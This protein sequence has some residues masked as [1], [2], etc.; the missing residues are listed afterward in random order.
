MVWAW[1]LEGLDG[2]TRRLRLMT[3][4]DW[5]AIGGS[6]PWSPAQ[7]HMARWQRA[8]STVARLTPTPGIE[9]TC[10]DAGNPAWASGKATLPQNSRPTTVQGTAREAQER[11]TATKT[12]SIEASSAP[13][14]RFGLGRPAS[15]PSATLSRRDRAPWCAGDAR[16]VD[17]GGVVGTTG[18][19]CEA[20]AD[21][22]TNTDRGT[23][24]TSRRETRYHGMGH[25]CRVLRYYPITQ[26]IHRVRYG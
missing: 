4:R 2:G 20:G 25:D 23:R 16:G 21:L 15:R 1:N 17:A 11:R 6:V 26:Q 10:R 5:V 14:D 7:G 9:P 22:G 24:N 18:L 8:P 13:L 3:P 12:G 19:G